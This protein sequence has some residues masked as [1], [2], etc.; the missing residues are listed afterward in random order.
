M[1]ITPR[2]IALPFGL[3]LA[4][5]TMLS[6]V[7]NA[8]ASDG[9]S[10]VLR[11]Q[12]DN[13]DALMRMVDLQIGAQGL[14]QKPK[15]NWRR[16]A[17]V[18]LKR[19]PL[20]PAALRTVALVADARGDR[21]RAE[22]LMHL[23]ERLSRRDIPTELWLAVD[24][25][26]Q[27]ELKDMLTHIDLLLSSESA[28]GPLIYPTLTRALADKRLRDELVPLVRNDRPWL[29]SF[30]S[31]SLEN[32]VDPQLVSALVIEAGGLPPGPD[33]HQYET[34]LIWAL[35]AKQEYA[36]ASSLVRRLGRTSQALLADGRLNDETLS[37]DLGP[38]GWTASLDPD[39]TSAFSGDGQVDA[40]IAP[41]RSGTILQR[42]FMLPQGTYRVAATARSLNDDS[43]PT[44]EIDAYCVGDGA[45]TRLADKRAPVGSG[46]S[47][48]TVEFAV[49]AGC[50]IQR[51]TFSA[52]AD[53]R[54]VASEL[55]LFD[56]SLSRK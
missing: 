35:A 48:M 12:P 42:L 30:L 43:R 54:Q 34:D 55:S 37:T 22:N 41:S 2:W 1:K 50:G 47:R 24:S 31:F 32:N 10:L 51:L 40:R 45:S 13:A 8:Y 16:D 17:I 36:M 21:K 39:A 33:Y 11:L 18:A 27:H 14:A 29:R 7:A 53:D 19:E 44:V 5:F 20:N 9:P 23:S 52:G 3:A 38:F 6:A 15:A 4:G 28:A 46:N 26:R 25:A 49:P 56:I